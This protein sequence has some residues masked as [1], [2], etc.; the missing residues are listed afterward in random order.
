MRKGILWAAALWLGG[1]GLAVAQT[2]APPG[3]RAMLGA[4]ETHAEELGAPPDTSGD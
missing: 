1:S 4:P 3:P 2:S